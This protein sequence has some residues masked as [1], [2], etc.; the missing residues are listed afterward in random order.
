MQGVLVDAC[1][2]VAIVEAGIN[3]DVSIQAAVG[4]F[5]LQLLPSID[6]ELQSLQENRKATLL[7]DLLRE[8]A[9]LVESPPNSSAH[10]DDQ[11]LALAKSLKQPVLTV[12]KRLKGRLHHAGC[13]VIELTKSNHL[14]LIE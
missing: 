14:R 10:P 9:E 1:G 13:S 4:P 3:L 6:E 11:L 2:W 7:L 8:R 5:K 12:D